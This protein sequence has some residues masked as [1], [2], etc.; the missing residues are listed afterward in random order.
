MQ[1]LLALEEGNQSSI[2]QWGYIRTTYAC[3]NTPREHGRK[4][5]FLEDVKEKCMKD[6]INQIFHVSF[7]YHSILPTRYTRVDHLLNK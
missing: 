6:S 4:S 2:D 3:F 7:N 1:T 5:N